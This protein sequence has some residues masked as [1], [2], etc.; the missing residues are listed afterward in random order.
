MGLIAND[1][2]PLA[3]LGPGKVRKGD[4]VLNVV[5]VGH[6]QRVGSMMN[7]GIGQITADIS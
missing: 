7:K 6:C 2:D 4:G 3:R 5:P 1:F